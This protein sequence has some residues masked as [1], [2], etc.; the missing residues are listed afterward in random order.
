MERVRD[1]ES[2]IDS[3]AEEKDA[4]ERSLVMS[5]KQYEKLNELYRTVRE[6]SNA[7]SI[8]LIAEEKAKFLKHSAE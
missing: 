2:H 5:K 7:G 1:L 3:M 8:T 6:K 4:I